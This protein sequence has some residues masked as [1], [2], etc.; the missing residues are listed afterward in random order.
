MLL[1]RFPKYRPGMAVKPRRLQWSELP[2]EVRM[3]LCV[4]DAMRVAGPRC[5]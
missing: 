1:E 5:A 2:E 3:M 4:V